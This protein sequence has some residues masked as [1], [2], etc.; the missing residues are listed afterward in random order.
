MVK[1]KQVLHLRRLVLEQGESLAIATRKSGMCET[2]ARK[3][4]RL[5]NLPSETVKP[6]TWRTRKDPFEDVWEEAKGFLEMNP[7]LEV[8][9][10]FWEL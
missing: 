10:L 5:G 9:A 4:M 1:D 8:T 3:Y 2:T 6:R 7:N